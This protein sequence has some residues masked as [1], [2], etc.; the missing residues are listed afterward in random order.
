MPQQLMHE[1]RIARRQPLQC[2]RCMQIGAGIAE[3]TE[4]ALDRGQAERCKMQCDRAI[5]TTRAA[6]QLTERTA[7]DDGLGPIGG[8]HVQV[9]LAC[10]ARKRV[11]QRDAGFVGPVHIFDRYQQWPHT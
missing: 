7:R 11:E 10:R 8:D 6:D 9:A 4:Q 1:Q 3:L 2:L 5:A